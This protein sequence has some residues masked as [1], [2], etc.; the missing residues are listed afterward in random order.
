[1]VTYFSYQ[2]DGGTHSMWYVFT[3]KIVAFDCCVGTNSHVIVIEVLSVP[4]QNDD[5]PEKVTMVGSV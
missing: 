1:M 5:L 3:Q 2:S 4:V